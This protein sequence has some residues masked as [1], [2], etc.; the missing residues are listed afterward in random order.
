MIGAGR[1]PFEHSVATKIQFTRA[2][3]KRVGRE[4]DLQLNRMSTE[5]KTV[6]DLLAFVEGVGMVLESARHAS[7]PN[8]VALRTTN[9]RFVVFLYKF[10]PG[11]NATRIISIGSGGRVTPGFL[12]QTAS[13]FTDRRP[14]RPAEGMSS[15]QRNSA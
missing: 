1:V 15:E 11:Q 4:P 13:P 2:R 7:V 5:K 6:S 3:N 8:L 10:Y 12:W 9:V 14:I